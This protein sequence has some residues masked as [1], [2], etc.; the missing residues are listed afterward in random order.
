VTVAK[1]LL[2][3]EGIGDV[4]FLGALLQDLNLQDV[5]VDKIGGNYTRLN[6]DVVQNRIRR[7]ADKGQRVALALDADSGDTRSECEKIIAENG[8]PV[9]RAFF[10]PNDADP[11]DLED[12]LEQAIVEEHQCVLDCFQEYED[13]LTAANPKYVKPNKKAKIYA[14]CEAIGSEPKEDKRNYLNPSWWNLDIGALEPLKSFLR[15]L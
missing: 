1:W 8:L 11:G 5:E 15:A 4:V 10:I 6:L 13:C 14:Y 12:L 9:D 2:L 7:A 3:G